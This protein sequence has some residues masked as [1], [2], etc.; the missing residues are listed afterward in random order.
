[1]LKVEVVSMYC[2]VQNTVCTT[3]DAFKCLLQR[4]IKLTIELGKKP[5]SISVFQSIA[6]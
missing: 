2:A 5:V 1:M 3:L 6:V 4:H